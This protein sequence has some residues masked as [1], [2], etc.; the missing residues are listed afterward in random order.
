MKVLALNSSPRT[1]NKSKTELLLN[2][3]VRGMR[4]AGADVEEVELRKKSIR[5]C[6]GCFTCWTKTPGVCIHKDDMT[7]ELFPKWKEADLVVYATP[8]YHFT[9]NA[10]MKA[11]IER[12]LPAL[13]PFFKERDGKTS[14][15]ARF[16]HPKVVVLSVAGFPEMSVFDQLSS[17]ANF[18][19]G[20]SGALV[21]EIYRPMAESMTTPFHRAKAEEALQATVQAGREIVETMRVSEETLAR[22]TQP[23]VK[24]PRPF[25]EIANLMWK[26]CIAEGVTPGELAE[27]RLVPRPDSLESF[28]AIL[29]MGFRPE[30]A[31]DMRATIQFRFTGEVEGACR[32]RI[33]NSRIEAA[34]GAE[35]SPDLA[36]EAPFSL[37]M[38]ILAG[39][40]DGRRM[41][42]E[43]KY[44]VAGDL[45]LLAGLSRLFG[46]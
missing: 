38:D 27:R 37:W 11:F 31:G 33:E 18:V 21:A 32:F 20:R 30:E 5:S 36:I 6:I 42:M 12:T 25:F 7:R 4:E 3:L 34:V 41:F 14:H 44:K 45:S 9:A 16:R 46:G 15:P 2:H 40:A 13:Q 26:T 29:S 43:Q 17:W 23:L 19:F 22:V 39:K 8:L 24:D 1:G 10:S 35:E 28:M